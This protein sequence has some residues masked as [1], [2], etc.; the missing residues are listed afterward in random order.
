MDIK[1]IIKSPEKHLESKE[2]MAFV[3]AFIK[4]KEKQFKEVE[5]KIKEKLDE[6]MEREGAK[7]MEFTFEN[8]KGSKKFKVKKV[9]QAQIE[10]YNA[11]T[12]FN[13]IGENA[14]EYFKIDN[15]KLKK[16][17][18]ELVKAGQITSEVFEKLQKDKIIKQKK[19]Y[20][21]INELKK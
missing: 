3:L 12:V 19:G 5:K 2:K 21:S 13:V 16:K 1:E 15:A 18:A 11:Q 14:L 4:H 10:E 7:E 8:E 20:L 9:E 6:I 17:L